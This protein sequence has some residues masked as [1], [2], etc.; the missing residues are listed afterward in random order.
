LFAQN[1]CKFDSIGA[2][3]PLHFQNTES[4]PVRQKPI[5]IQSPDG[6]YVQLHRPKPNRSAFARVHS[7]S[8]EEDS[9]IEDFEVDLRGREKIQTI[10]TE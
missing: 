5:R 3:A 2:R 8:E 7:E 10:N 1:G 6:N 9:G 4:A